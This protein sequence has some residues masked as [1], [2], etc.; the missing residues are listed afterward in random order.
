ASYPRSDSRSSSRAARSAGASAWR[1]L[2]ALQAQFWRL[3]AE[4]A[5]P[6]LS[7]RPGSSDERKQPAPAH[8][9]GP[10][11]RVPLL[12]VRDR[13]ENDLRASDKVL[14]RNIA[15]LAE[16]AAVGG[17][18]AVVAHHEEM[19]RRHDVFL[20]V[21]VETV[22]DQIECRI[23]HAVRQRLAPALHALR[24][25]GLIGVDE[26]FNALAL[27]WLAVDVEQAFAHLDAV[28]G[29]TDHALDVVGRV[30]LRQA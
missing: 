4:A 21:V 19:T 18:V 13:E 15:D 14:K 30:V 3:N 8:R 24:R 2:P 17:I 16:H 1:V 23:G 12:A 28:A 29:Q 25:G 26:V 5:V 9:P 20:R 7:L 11:P 10:A 22:V 27:H 6:V